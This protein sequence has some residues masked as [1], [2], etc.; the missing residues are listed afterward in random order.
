ML[1]TAKLLSDGIQQQ[2][3]DLFR[4]R[5]HVFLDKCLEAFSS[6][7]GHVADESTATDELIA[8]I[9]QGIT[10]ASTAV[11]GQNDPDFKVWLNRPY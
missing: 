11:M 7:T 2:P 3:H 8:L 6:G 4:P 10:N 9:T 1:G 5:V